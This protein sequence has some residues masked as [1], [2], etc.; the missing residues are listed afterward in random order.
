M[1]AV[2][3]GGATLYHG[4]CYQI[5]PTLGW[6]PVLCMDPPYKFR[7]AGGGAFREQR[8]HTDQIAAE[9]LDQ[10]FDYSIINPLLCGSVVVFCHNDQLP[11]LTT[12][13]DGSF[14]RFAVCAWHK[15]NPMP[16]A[17]KHYMPDTEF[18]VHAWNRGH[19]PVGTLAEKGRFVMSQ[20]GRSKE[21]GHPTVKPDKVMDKIIANVSGDL[22]CDPFMGTGSTGVAV[23]K[24]GRRFIGIEKNKVHFETA[25]RRIRECQLQQEAA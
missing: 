8:G 10:G 23:L 16:M 2:T 4:D 11:K 3:I 14:D 5:L 24:A 1:I 19:H 7:T 9:G 22:V 18:Y 25:C 15:L 21:F 20:V 13:L 6:L 12:Y 17:N